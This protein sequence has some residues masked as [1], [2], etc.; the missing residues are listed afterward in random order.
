MTK[1]LRSISFINRIIWK[2]FTINLV[3]SNK[4]LYD[5]TELQRR[6]ANDDYLFFR[7]LLEPNDLITLRRE[8][9]N[10]IK[11]KCQPFKLKEL[12]FTLQI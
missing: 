1:A 11:N 12:H 7:C 10:V 5:P 6:M 8:M 4:A 2:Y 3:G 9:L